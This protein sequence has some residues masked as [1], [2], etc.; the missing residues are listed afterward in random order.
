MSKTLIESFLS[1]LTT[2][3]SSPHPYAALADYLTLSAKEKVRPIWAQAI[4]VAIIVT[5]GF[6][7]IGSVWI[8]AIG[9][10]HKRFTLGSITK[11]RFVRPNPPMCMAVGIAGYYVCEMIQHITIL[12]AEHD[13]SDMDG[14]IT[15]YGIKFMCFAWGNGVHHICNIWDPPWQRGAPQDVK[16][17]VPPLIA[18]FVNFTFSSLGSVAVVFVVSIYIFVDVEQTKMVGV[19]DPVKAALR[20][21]DKD[22]AEFDLATAL[23]TLQPLVR[24]IT[25]TEKL[26]G[27]FKIGIAGW[28]A[29]GFLQVLIQAICIYLVVLERRKMGASFNFKEAFTSITNTREENTES[30]IDYRREQSI[31]ILISMINISAVIIY[32]PKA[33]STVSSIF[34][35]L[36]ICAGVDIRNL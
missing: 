36:M 13:I 28:V 34:L 7:L 33:I 9:I 17:R 35:S 19:F 25:L 18:Y 23:F 26:I 29:C 1:G 32:V 20:D 27:H 11:D 24:I 31:H 30:S 15:F 6:M 4:S 10:Q 8:C 22:R 16:S 2:I 3:S 12:L 5:S 21:L 14:R